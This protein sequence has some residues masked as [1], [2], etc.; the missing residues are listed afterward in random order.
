MTAVIQATLNGIMMGSM[1]GLTALGLT[2]IFGVMKVINFAHGSLLMVG[3]FSAY[4]LIKLTGI[5]PYLA[6]LI[7]PPVLYVFGY[8]LQDVVIKPVFKAERQTRE[9][10]TVIIVTTGVWYVLDNLS[11]MLFGA[12]YRTVRTAISNKSMAL[13]PYILSIP[14]FSGFVIA[15]LATIGLALFMRKT[16]IGM[17]LRATALDREAANL[18]G[19][20]QYK[21][22]NIAFGLG[23]AIAGIAGCVL[24]PF[25]YVYPSVGVVFDIRAFI[26]VVL[27]GL[28]SIPGALLGGLVI[29]LIESVFSQFMASTW[30]E[31][32]IYAIFL[33]ILFVKPS[34]F[35]GNKQDW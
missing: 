35:F 28:G 6:L 10:A 7:V 14:K 19:I 30:T 8:Y 15:V 20:D 25:Y 5:H 17:A 4:W 29:G 16:K 12:E 31:A 18:M 21:V 3:M 27:G 34:G 13:G 24:I 32:I 2:L 22:Y 33:I 9:P 26:I 23:T 1:Y 11:L